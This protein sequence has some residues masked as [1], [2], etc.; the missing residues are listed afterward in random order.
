MILTEQGQPPCV[1]RRGCEMF[2]AAATCEW[3]AFPI[4]SLFVLSISSRRVRD[5]Q[6]DTIFKYSLFPFQTPDYLPGR[7]TV[8]RGQVCEVFDQYES[9]G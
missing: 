9:K 4:S 2:R 7:T 6:A 3:S 8:A 1:I 5:V